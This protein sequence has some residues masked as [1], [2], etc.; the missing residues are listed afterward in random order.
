M[1]I[2][3]YVYVLDYGKLI[4]Q[5]SPETV[6]AD[7]AVIEAYLGI[8]R[9]G[10]KDLCRT[11]DLANG[12]CARTG[13]TSWSSRI[14]LP[15]MADQALHGSRSPCREERSWRSG[16]E[17]G[18]E[19]HPP[20]HHFRT[21]QAEPGL[22]HRSGSGDH[23]LD[24]ETIVGRGLCQVPEGRRLFP[25]LSVQDNLVVGSSGGGTGE[26]ASRTISPTYTSYSRFW[27]SGV[28][29][30]RARFQGGSSRCSP[31]DAPWWGRPSLLLLDEPSMGL[32]P[33]TAERIFEAL[34][35][36]NKQG[37]TM[38][39]VEQS[40]EIALGTSGGCSADGSRGGLPG[41]RT[42]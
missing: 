19:D 36:L 2:S 25:G 29:R 16:G 22:D 20:S 23:S 28:S 4:S 26:R 3:D 35:E 38:L 7:P 6:Q 34:A 31:S 13:E 18:G 39:M 11:R 24:P 42:P 32:A 17:R 15:R 8:K 12:T 14:S 5:G 27:G 30:R 40:A 9:E 33:L 1:G 37:L 41:R 21:S 10:Q